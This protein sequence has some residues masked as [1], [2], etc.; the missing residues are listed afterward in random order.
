MFSSTESAEYGTAYQSLT[1]KRSWINLNIA[2]QLSEVKY[3]GEYGDNKYVSE[4][5]QNFRNFYNRCDTKPG[6]ILPMRVHIV[7]CYTEYYFQVF[8]QI[9]RLIIK[10]A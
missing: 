6:D 5:W 7:I 2:D 1:D 4:Q 3:G 10:S 9:H 8:K